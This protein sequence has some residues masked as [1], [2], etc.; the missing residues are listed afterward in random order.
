MY[1]EKMDSKIDLAVLLGVMS[2]CDKYLGEDL[3]GP[4]IDSVIQM[5]NQENCLQICESSLKMKRCI[6]LK[7]TAFLCVTQ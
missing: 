4:C 1:L 6:R 5:I 2:L 7:K 3:L